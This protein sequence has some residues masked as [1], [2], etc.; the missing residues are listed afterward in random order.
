MKLFY[1]QLEGLQMGWRARTE[2]DGFQPSTGFDIQ[3]FAHFI[4]FFPDIG[5]YIRQYQQDLATRQTGV[6]L[7]SGLLPVLRAALP[8]CSVMVKLL[9]TG[10]AMVG[11]STWHEYRAMGYRVLKRYSL[12]YHLSEGGMVPPGQTMSGGDRG[13]TMSGGERVPGHT[14]SMSSYAGNL[15]SLDDFYIISSGLVTT[16]STLF[17]YRK[18]LYDKN[19]VIEMY[20]L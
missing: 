16:E 2:E 4:N 5:D 11:H 7:R 18:E 15:F 1:T 17:I 8:S 3:W 12:P 9:E 13:H 14:M 10:E 19:K 20:L 6:G